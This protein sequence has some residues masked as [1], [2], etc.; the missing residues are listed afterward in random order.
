MIEKGYR[1]GKAPALMFGLT[2]PALGLRRLSKLMYT[3]KFGY[4][5]QLGRHPGK[6]DKKPADSIWMTGRQAVQVW[7]RHCPRHDS[8]PRAARSP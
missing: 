8:G 3:L 7:G 5:T 1:L 4:W 6:R 2:T